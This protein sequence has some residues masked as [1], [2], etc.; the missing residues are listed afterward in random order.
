MKISLLLTFSIFF[1]IA[2]SACETTSNDPTQASVSA[3]PWNKPASWEGA[4][5]LGGFGFTGTH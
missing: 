5:A 4:G 1:A 2:F 3:I